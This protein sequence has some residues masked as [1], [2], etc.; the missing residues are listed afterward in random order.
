MTRRS[1][2]PWQNERERIGVE[3][4]GADAWATLR[5]LEGIANRLRT[6]AEFR[7]PAGEQ[8]AT[9]ATRYADQ[10]RQ[11]ERDEGDSRHGAASVLRVQ[12]LLDHPLFASWVHAVLLNAPDDRATYRRRQ[13]RRRRRW[14]EEHSADPRFP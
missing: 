5:Q 6:H 11:G 9:T 12:L 8:A 3:T 10:L 1:R 14:L 7:T 13:P 4:M 2:V